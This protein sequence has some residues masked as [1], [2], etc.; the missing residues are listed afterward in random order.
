MTMILSLIE[1]RSDIDGVLKQYIDTG[2][3]HIKFEQQLL[4][5]AIRASVAC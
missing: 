4:G 1:F 2:P 3:N 5:L